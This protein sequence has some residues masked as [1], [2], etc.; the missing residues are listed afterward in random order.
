MGK[1]IRFTT[2]VSGIVVLVVPLIIGIMLVSKSYAPTLSIDVTKVCED[3]VG[4]GS[5]IMFS[6]VVTNTS[7]L[8]L[9]VTVT[10]DHAGVVFGPTVIEAGASANYSGSYIPTE[11]PSTNVVTARGVLFYEDRLWPDHW[12]EAIANA[13]CEI[14]EVPCEWT[15]DKSADQSQLTLSLGQSF[16]VNYSVA[17]NGSGDCTPVDVT[18]TYAGFLGTVTSASQ[19]FYYPRFIGPY[20]ICGDYKV[21]NTASLSTGASDSWTV[22]VHVPCLEGCTLT[23][24][25]WKTHSEYG[26]APYD[27]TWAQLSDGADTLFFDKGASWYEV[28]W[29]PP[30]KGDV[31]YILAHQYIAAYLNGLNGADTSTLGTALTDAA[32]L[33]DEY[34]TKSIPR[35]IRPSFINLASTLDQ[36]NN[37]YTGP[38][39]CS[40]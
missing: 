17:V 27:D 26:P 10:D 7:A 30:K 3:A 29:T 33:L 24:G 13:T 18:D 2:K 12:V 15:I 36:Y 22:N 31:Y 40:E 5:P 11:S 20:G 38:G 32:A 8:S 23:Q 28:L 14:K 9:S 37:G 16:Q 6:G 4:P 1:I 21:E 19:T 34:D 25:Y 39:H 35:S